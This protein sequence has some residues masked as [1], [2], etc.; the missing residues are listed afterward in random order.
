MGAPGAFE[1]RRQELEAIFHSKDLVSDEKVAESF[2]DIMNPVSLHRTAESSI[3][4]VYDG[5]LLQYLRQAKIMTVI[6]DSLFVHGSIQAYNL[7][8][9]PAGS[10]VDGNVLTE[11]IVL[12]DLRKWIVALNQFMSNEVNIHSMIHFRPYNSFSTV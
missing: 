4:N 11:P 2:V 10:I 8:W 6:G 12:K 9:L 1:Y 5:I 3:R 7:G